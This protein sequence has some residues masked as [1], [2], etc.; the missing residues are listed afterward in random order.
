MLL[1]PSAVLGE[2]DLA[3]GTNLIWQLGLFMVEKGP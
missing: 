1:R 2:K 3:A